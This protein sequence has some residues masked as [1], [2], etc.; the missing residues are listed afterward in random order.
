[1][2][3]HAR[4][5]GHPI[6]QMLV[7]IPFGLLVVGAGLDVVQRFTHNTWMPMMSFW[8]L[9]IGV[10]FALLAAAFGVVDLAAIPNGTRAKRVGGL[11]AIGNVVMLGLFGVALMMRYDT[12]MLPAP[13]KALALEVAGMLLG[14][15]TGWLGGELVDRLGVGVEDNANLDAPSSLSGRASRTSAARVTVP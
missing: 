2:R 1:M 5:F 3:S 9:T 10:A 4:L 15:V 14:V 7:P 11:H 13:T 12:R 8:N 6:H